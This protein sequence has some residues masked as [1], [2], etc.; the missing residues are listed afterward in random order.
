M[1][2]GDSLGLGNVSESINLSGIGSTIGIIILA[3]VVLV[4]VGAFTFMHYSKKIKKKLFKY[5]IPIFI[6]VNGKFSRQDVDDAKEL[7]IPDSNVSLFYLKK[8]KIYIARPTR[9]MSKDEF[10]YY[11]SENGEWVNFDLNSNPTEDTLAFANYDHRDTR[12]AYTNLKD[13]IKRNYK[14]KS[15]VWWKDPTIMNIIAFVIMSLVFVGGCILILSRISILIKEL[16]PIS[17][18][19]ETASENMIKAVQISQNLNSGIGFS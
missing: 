2:L 16:A 4:I 19:F 15:V 13:L 12:Y 9:A 7:F 14:D 1:G 11:I 18:A 3:F 10:W 5:K 8:K 6:R 17:K